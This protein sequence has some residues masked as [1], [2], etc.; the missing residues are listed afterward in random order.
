MVPSAAVLEDAAGAY[1]LVASPDGH[2]LTKRPVEIGRTF[3]GMTAVVSGLRSTER[4]LT[5]STFFVDAER[6]LRADSAAVDVAP[7]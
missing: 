4:V 3:G 1:A 2:T 5:G 6:R 7:R